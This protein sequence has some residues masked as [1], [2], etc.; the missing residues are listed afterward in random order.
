MGKVHNGGQGHE[1]RVHLLGIRYLETPLYY[2]FNIP[3]LMIC[4][5]SSSLTQSFNLLFEVRVRESASAVFLFIHSFV[6]SRLVF[7]VLAV[8]GESREGRKVCWLGHW[9][10]C[11]SLISSINERQ[12]HWHL[13]RSLI[14]ETSF[15]SRK[16]SN[17]DLTWLSVFGVICYF[18][19][20][21]G[22]VRRLINWWPWLDGS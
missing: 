12:M 11:S 21:S 5:C 18:Y 8:F 20:W 4:N 10:F 9:L 3:F 13:P 22:L 2:D 1:I 7:I 16:H 14:L 15:V 6:L 17:I 19:Y